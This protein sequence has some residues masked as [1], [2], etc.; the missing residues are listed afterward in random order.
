MLY[1]RGCPC[2]M[3]VPL[4]LAFRLY[5]TLVFCAKPCV[6]FPFVCT[7]FVHVSALFVSV[8][9]AVVDLDRVRLCCLCRNRANT[10]TEPARELCGCARGENESDSQTFTSVRTW[11][12]FAIRKRLIPRLQLW[13]RKKQTPNHH[14]ST[15]NSRQTQGR[16]AVL[17]M[18]VTE[19][20]RAR[21]DSNRAFLAFAS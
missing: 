13:N 19:A 2:S 20:S 12:Q 9:V 16:T 21:K 11:L 15:D 7:S 4:S 14:P 6:A 1:L 8:C 10:Q 18:V 5:H 3:I 17:T